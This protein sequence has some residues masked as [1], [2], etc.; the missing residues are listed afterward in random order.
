[1]K[2]LAPYV[3]YC[4]YCETKEASLPYRFLPGKF[5][6]SVITHSILM[7]GPGENFYTRD[8]LWCI[9]SKI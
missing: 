1:M 2:K 3:V 5:S 4:I 8:Q 7:G 9:L 6:Q